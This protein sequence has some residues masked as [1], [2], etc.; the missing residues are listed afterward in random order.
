VHHVPENM[1]DQKMAPSENENE[2]K[3]KKI[4]TVGGPLTN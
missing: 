2:I 4:I 3:F 1:G